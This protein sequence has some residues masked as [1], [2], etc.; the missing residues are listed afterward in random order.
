MKPLLSVQDLGVQFYTSNGI[1]KAVDGVSFDIKKGEV[2]ALVGESG[3]GKSTTALAIMRLIPYP[4]KITRGK[5]I[6]KGTDLLNFVGRRYG[7]GA[8][9]RDKHD[10]PKS[11]NCFESCLQ[12]WLS[13]K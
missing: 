11:L 3:C 7:K 8:R 2:F 10:I 1:V 4:G 13:D 5:I 9:K 12:D 6:Y